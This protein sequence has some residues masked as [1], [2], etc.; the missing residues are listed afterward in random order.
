M[1]SLDKKKIFHEIAEY[2]IKGLWK[3]TGLMGG[4]AEFWGKGP[5]EMNA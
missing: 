4:F 3:G 5:H 1:R 2:W